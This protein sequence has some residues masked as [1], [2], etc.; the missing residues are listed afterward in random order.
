MFEQYCR[1]HL[2]TLLNCLLKVVGALYFG[3]L[4]QNEEADLVSS[5]LHCAN[6]SICCTVKGI[7][8]KQDRSRYADTYCFILCITVMYV[9]TYRLLACCAIIH[10]VQKNV[11]DAIYVIYHLQ[12][13]PV[14]FQTCP[15]NLFQSLRNEVCTQ[16]MLYASL[17]LGA[18][19]HEGYSTLSVCLSVSLLATSLLV[20][21]ICHINLK[22]NQETGNVQTT[23]YCNL[24]RMHRALTH[25]ILTFL[26]I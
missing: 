10:G 3:Q 21:I 1:H 18:H 11:I 22:R 14:Y 6:C 4:L 2:I 24:V 8:N 16:L 9:Y 12:K 20:H 26:P 23:K 7:T 25:Q 19:A 15:V 5:E 17:T 13:G